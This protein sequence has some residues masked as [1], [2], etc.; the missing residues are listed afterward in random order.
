MEKRRR[1]R[2]LFRKSGLKAAQLELF[3]SEFI[4]ELKKPEVISI[5][6]AIDRFKLAN[7]KQI[8]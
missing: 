8:S 5:I 6:H 2:R 7:L 3:I 1:I 4:E